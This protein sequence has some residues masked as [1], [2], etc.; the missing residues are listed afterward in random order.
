MPAILAPLFQQNSQSKVVDESL[1]GRPPW[2]MAIAELQD[3]TVGDAEKW[4]DSGLYSSR[5]LFPISQ[6]AR[7]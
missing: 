5:L 2:A 3:L 6:Q 1:W 4:L 7:S